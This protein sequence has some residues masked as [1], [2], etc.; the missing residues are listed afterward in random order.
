MSSKLKVQMLKNAFGPK[1]RLFNGKVY[2]MDVAEAEMYMD[3]KACHVVKPGIKVLDNG[4]QK[5]VW[6]NVPYETPKAKAA[7]KAK[8]REKAT[9]KANKK[10]ET[11]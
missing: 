7:G 11:R 6:I 1:V 10:K 9:L 4:K 8:K 2:D 5:K 3:A